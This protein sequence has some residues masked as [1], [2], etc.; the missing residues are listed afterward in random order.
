[1]ITSRHQHNLF[2]IKLIERVLTINEYGVRITYKKHNFQ[3]EY[4]IKEA[5]NKLLHNHTWK[6]KILYPFTVNR[7]GF[8]KTKLEIKL[9]RSEY[10]SNKVN[11]N[12]YFELKIKRKLTKH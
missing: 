7:L 9:L 3:S 11:V 4:I 5:N 2:K 8:V 10:L 12:L 1:M 6:L